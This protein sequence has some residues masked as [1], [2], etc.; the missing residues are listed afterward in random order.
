MPTPF[1]KHNYDYSEYASRVA[2]R[3]IYKSLVDKLH[4][5]HQGFSLLDMGGTQADFQEGL[6]KVLEVRLSDRI[7]E[8]R[9]Q[10]RFRRPSYAKYRQLTATDA[11]LMTGQTGDLHKLDVDFYVY[12]Y[13]NIDLSWEEAVVV[14]ARR[15]VRLHRE[16][17][18]QPED[19]RLYKRKQQRIF[20]F[21]FHK[22]DQAGCIVWHS[23]EL[24]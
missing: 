9:V 5:R 21:S 15:F 8:Y 13:L 1:D 14:D 19:V 6:D 16:G 20:A 7:V 11:N 23:R 4:P 24:K 2:E 17:I 22:L 10:E 3:T 12:G 18:L